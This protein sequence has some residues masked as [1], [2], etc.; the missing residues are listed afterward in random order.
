VKFEWKITN[1]KKIIIRRG[2]T[3]IL[4]I[5]VLATPLFPQVEY[6]LQDALKVVGYIE[7]LQEE[8]LIEYSGPQREIELTESELNAYFAYLIDV[9]REE[10]MKE[11]RLKL[12]ED[13]KIEGK[14]FID[15]K[16][17]KLPKIL[18]SEM[19]FYFGAKL[20]IKEKKVR[21][22][23]DKLFLEDQEIN[24]VILDMVIF[25]ASKI[26]GT[27]SGSISDWYVLPFGIEDIRTKRGKA[28]FFY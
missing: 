12:F 13:N 4:L 22:N 20:D 24:K 6:S 27:E 14:I 19:N 15:L 8:Q 2:F 17:Q 3:R 28:V 21:I 7:R 25:V 16:G 5:I 26:N 9:D 10:V 18:R 1:C 11:L 23:I